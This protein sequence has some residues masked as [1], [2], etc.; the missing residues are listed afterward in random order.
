VI[1]FLA[2]ASFVAAVLAAAGFDLATRRIPDLLSV[3]IVGAFV[4]AAPASG[5]DLVALGRHLLAGAFVFALG[6]LCFSRGWLGG[7]DVKLLA[8]CAVWLGWDALFPFA[9]ATVMAGGVL[10]VAV[11]ALRRLP[12]D[13]RER[14]PLSVLAAERGLPY[15]V[16]IAVGAIVLNGISQG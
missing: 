5:V 3:A 7:G 12:P 16:A 14:P 2:N 4:M 15:A 9:L 1:M 8:A 10:A 6:A 11:L 13:W